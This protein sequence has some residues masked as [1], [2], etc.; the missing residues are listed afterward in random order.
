[1]GRRAG[2]GGGVPKI[3]SI[4]NSHILVVV[5]ETPRMGTLTSPKAYPKP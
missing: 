3:G 1:M 5:M 4:Q 2:G